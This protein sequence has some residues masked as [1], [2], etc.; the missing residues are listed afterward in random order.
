MNTVVTCTYSS[1]MKIKNAREDLIATGIPQEEIHV[2]EEAHQM[3]V[4]IADEARPEIMEILN[5]HE[6]TTLN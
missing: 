6:P 1:A 3:Q 4:L 2:D 5:R